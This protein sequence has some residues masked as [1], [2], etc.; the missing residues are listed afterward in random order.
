MNKNTIKW[1]ECQVVNMDNKYTH[2]LYII[3]YK[4]AINQSI[5]Q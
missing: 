5:K 3:W 2:K 1:N 4:Q